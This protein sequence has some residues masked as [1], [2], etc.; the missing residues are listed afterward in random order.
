MVVTNVEVSGGTGTSI[1]TKCLKIK[2]KCMLWH[3][4]LPNENAFISFFF[5]ISDMLTHVL[6]PNYFYPTLAVFT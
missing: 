2:T 1:M 6:P 5:L 3:F 4:Y